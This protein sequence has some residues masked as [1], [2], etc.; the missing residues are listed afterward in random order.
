MAKLKYLK[1]LNPVFV[2]LIFLVPF[3]SGSYFHWSTLALAIVMALVNGY[4]VR[5]MLADYKNLYQFSYFDSL[6]GIPNRLSADLYCNRLGSLENLSVAV[7]DLDNLKATNDNYG[8]AR[9]D[10]LIKNF[11]ALFFEYASKYGF[12]ARAGGDEFIAFINSPVSHEE[13]QQ[14]CLELQEAIDD[15]NDTSSPHIS[16][17]IGCLHKGEASFH[18]IHE[19][20]A[21]AN[22]QMYE[23]KKKKKAAEAL[24]NF[25]E[26]RQ[27]NV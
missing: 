12:A 20:I 11:A 5:R 3:I 17:S 6:T 16:Y 1:F 22:A 25:T 26:R 9:G 24:K 18:T 14:F 10:V 13:M 21:Y 2:L 8:H 15:Y 4:M 27:Q 7:A 23:I 19:L